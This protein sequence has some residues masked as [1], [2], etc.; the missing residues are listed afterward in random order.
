MGIYTYEEPH[1]PRWAE[2]RNFMLSVR[3]GKPVVVPFEVGVADAQGMIYGNRAIETGQKVY[4]PEAQPP[5]VTGEKSK[6]V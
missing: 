3:D 6:K 4:W 1:D 5:E 2:M